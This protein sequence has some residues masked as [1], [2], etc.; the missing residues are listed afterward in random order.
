MQETTHSAWLKAAA[1]KGNAQAAFE[2]GRW[3]MRRATSLDDEQTGRDYVSRAAEGGY[4]PAIYDEIVEPLY[5]GADNLE[6]LAEW[7]RFAI[8]RN[9]GSALVYFI[10]GFL[11]YRPH[12]WHA[13][14]NPRKVRIGIRMCH[15]LLD[16]PQAA[17]MNCFTMAR[18][19]WCLSES[20]R[21]WAA[22][23]GKSLLR[24]MVEVNGSD[25][26]ASMADFLDW[27]SHRYF[28]G[29]CECQAR[30]WR[31]RAA[32]ETNGAQ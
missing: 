26:C 19:V 14:A 17:A 30:L 24:R 16:S 15:M 12:F 21:P 6:E 3:V 18:M 5:H 32:A 11:M 25:F 2:Y 23:L 13:P 7:F 8:G 20:E 31:K 28:P 29:D 1:A 9:S 10:H 4:L 22:T 27:A